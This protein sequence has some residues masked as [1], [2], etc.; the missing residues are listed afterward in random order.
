MFQNLLVVTGA[1]PLPE[2]QMSAACSS[3][4]AEF[5]AVLLEEGCGLAPHPFLR[6]LAA[7]ISDSNTL[8]VLKLSGDVGVDESGEGSW[9]EAL[10]AWRAPVLMLAQP[11]PDGRF[12]GIVPASVAFA[13]ALNLSL[14]GLVQLG[15]EWD[16]SARRHDGL[17][18]CGCL[19]GPDDDPRGLISCLQHRQGVLARGG[20]AG[21]A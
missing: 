18:W 20:V 6:E 3:L 14:L 17:P 4:A 19:Q 2:L 10:A 1:G 21:S 7:N 8:T 13:R 12:S 5:G 11:R 9:M 16:A 15:G